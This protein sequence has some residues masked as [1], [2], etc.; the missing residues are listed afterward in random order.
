M[1]PGLPLV[2]VA[3]AALLPPAA[4]AGAL[5]ECQVPAREFE[6]VARCLTALDL[7]TL[8]ALQRAEQRAAAAARE[9]DERTQRG[10]TAHAALAQSARAFA[11]YQSAQCDYVHATMPGASVRPKTAGPTAADLARV[12]CRIDLARQRIAELGY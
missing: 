7:E 2:L 3:M 10:N 6:A 4:A 12:A 9:Q 1:T 8:A 5:A 11:L